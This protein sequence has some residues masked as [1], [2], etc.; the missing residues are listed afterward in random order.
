MVAPHLDE[1]TV[2]SAATSPARP[3]TSRASTA[4]ESLEVVRNGAAKGPTLVMR[5]GNGGSTSTRLNTGF[6][7]RLSVD[8][9]MSVCA[10]MT[11]TP[12]FGNGSSAEQ[13]TRAELDSIADFSREGLSGQELVDLFNLE[14]RDG[15]VQCT[16]DDLTS[17][18][19]GEVEALE[20]R[21][22]QL[23]REVESERRGRDNRQAKRS[24]VMSGS[25][26]SIL[27][28]EMETVEGGSQSRSIETIAPNASIEATGRKRTFSDMADL[29]V[30]GTNFGK[31][32]RTDSEHR[33]AEISGS[34]SAPATL[35][36]PTP[37]EFSEQERQLLLTFHAGGSKDQV[38][39]G[40]FNEAM[41]IYGLRKVPC[42]AESVMAAVAAAQSGAIEQQEEEY[43]D[44][45]IRRA[46]G[47]F[48]GIVQP[49][50]KSTAEFN[51][52]AWIQ[53][54]PDRSYV[55]LRKLVESRIGFALP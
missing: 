21:L 41:M 12:S 43:L 48:G 29:P 15:K 28:V 9:Q 17:V 51:A 37:K 40:Q 1:T 10:A 55:S 34:R 23:Q 26:G 19:E 42:S 14:F 20:S 35:V 31:K 25:M 50:E 33:R 22:A 54:R 3:A 4:P 46:V 8:G 18:M 38:L 47:L 5:L 45:E 39:A 24:R 16:T 7:Y 27:P 2:A 13:F 32:A 49:A 11:S 30:P 53:K 52:M 6:E 44:P 36:A